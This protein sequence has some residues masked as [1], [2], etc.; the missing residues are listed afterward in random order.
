MIEL[1]SYEKPQ[2]QFYSLRTGLTSK[3]SLTVGPANLKC[4]LRGLVQN[5]MPVRF[6]LTHDH[7]KKS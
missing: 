4:K 1:F 6:A 5:C 2:L 7:L 3:S